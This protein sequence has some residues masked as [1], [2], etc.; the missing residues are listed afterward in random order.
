MMIKEFDGKNLLIN[1]YIYNNTE[2]N[3]E[4]NE[5]IIKNEKDEKI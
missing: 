2:M 3:I 4:V 5:S 1:G